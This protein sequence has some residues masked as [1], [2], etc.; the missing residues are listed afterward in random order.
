MSTE[1]YDVVNGL[2]SVL[3]V[4]IGIAVVWLG[5]YFVKTMIKSR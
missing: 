4:A 2:L 3:Y 1:G 5:Y